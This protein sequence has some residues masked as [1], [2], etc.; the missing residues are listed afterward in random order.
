MT[1]NEDDEVINKSEVMVSTH[2]GFKCLLSA[3]LNFNAFS[4]C[5]LNVPHSKPGRS[6]YDS[7]DRMEMARILT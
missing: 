3:I 5:Q 6:L 7:A 1:S 2:M 4:I